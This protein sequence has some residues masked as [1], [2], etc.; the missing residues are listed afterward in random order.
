MRQAEFWPTRV[1]AGGS[2]PTG[3]AAS[4]ANAIRRRTRRGLSECRSRRK[5]TLS[6]AGGR[7]P[8]GPQDQQ[9]HGRP[10]GGCWTTRTSAS[11]ACRSPRVRPAASAWADAR[12]PA[13]AIEGCSGGRAPAEPA[14]RVAL[15][16]K[17]TTHAP[18]S[19]PR[20]AGPVESTRCPCDNEGRS[21]SAVASRPKRGSSHACSGHG[22][23]VAALGHDR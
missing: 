23:G 12:N 19:Y 4:P 14:T 3:S 2:R 5:G 21:A 8:A 13:A 22:G 20:E 1:E 16:S 6:T 18:P 7:A 10:R 15:R 11:S 9:R 17:N